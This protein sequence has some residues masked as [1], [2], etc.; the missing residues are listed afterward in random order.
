MKD[1][2]PINEKSKGDKGYVAGYK[3][4]KI[5]LYAETLYKGR[6]KA[7]EHFKPTKKDA[8][9]LWILLAESANGEVVFQSTTG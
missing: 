9:S 2:K 4:Q 5:A 1:I 6:L 8:G 3:N 7:E